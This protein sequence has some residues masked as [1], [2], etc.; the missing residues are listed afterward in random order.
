MR[1]ISPAPPV[2]S[3]P[4]VTA[5]TFKM[6]SEFESD[7]AIRRV[8][9][10]I[11]RDLID[12]AHWNEDRC[13]WP[14]DGME[15]FCSGT[16]SAQTACG[17]VGPDLYSGTAGIGLFLANAAGVLASEAAKRTALGAIRQALW[18]APRLVSESR[19]GLYDGVTGIVYSAISVARLL[20]RSDVEEIALRIVQRARLADWTPDRADIIGGIAGVVCGLSALYRLTRNISFSS[21]LREYGDKLRGCCD[22]F[23]LN[24]ES[25]RMHLPSEIPPTG[26]AH[27]A[28]GIGLGLAEVY[29]HD[30]NPEYRRAAR[31]LFAY[32]DRFLNRATRNWRN[33]SRKAS[34]SEAVGDEVFGWCS[35]GAGIGLSRLRALEVWPDSADLIETVA[36]AVEGA[37]DRLDRIGDEPCQDATPCHGVGGIAELVATAREIRGN[38]ATGVDW[39][40]A[41]RTIEL[42]QRARLCVSGVRAG[43]TS[44]SLMVGSCGIGYTLLRILQPSTVKSVLLIGAGSR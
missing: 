16:R 3:S 24:L 9:A 37:T 12:T 25:G 7:A 23:H 40:R 28:S 20:N 11:C 10:E 6:P 2:E 31:A 18:E 5:S 27:G 13:T 39:E 34:R 19:L 44:R 29:V 43:V 26:M 1:Q 4:S 21:L 41:W 36:M 38:E 17:S 35:G 33:I 42:A 14:R 22:G 15:E 30:P 32:E 8:I